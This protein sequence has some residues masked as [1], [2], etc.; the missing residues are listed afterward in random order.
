MRRYFHSHS[1]PDGRHSAKDSSEESCV[2]PGT[3]PGLNP[4]TAPSRGLQPPAQSDSRGR[5]S[6]GVGRFHPCSTASFP[7]A[8]G[9]FSTVCVTGPAPP[10][11][12]YGNALARVPSDE[13]LFSL[14]AQATAQSGVQGSDEFFRTEENHRAALPSDLGTMGAGKVLKLVLIQS[15]FP[16]RLCR[17]VG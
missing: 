8:L 12:S 6:S 7:L 2:E 4:A 17:D 16:S 5:H 15:I 11:R 3:K 9:T 13:P 14:W 10:H 1:S